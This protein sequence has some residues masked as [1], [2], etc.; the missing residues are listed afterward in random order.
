ML[1]LGYQIKVLPQR[2]NT[3]TETKMYS[4]AQSHYVPAAIGVLVETFFLGS[5]LSTLTGTD[6]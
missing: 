1:K 4:A 5:M 6:P 3:I 2:P